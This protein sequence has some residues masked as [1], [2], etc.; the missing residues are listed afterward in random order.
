M[1]LYKWGSLFLD[2]SIGLL[3]LSAIVRTV[4]AVRYARLNGSG[5]PNEEQK[6]SL[7]KMTLPIAVAGLVFGIASLVLLL[8][9]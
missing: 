1:E 4:L 2:I 7:R 9:C 3:L 6:K 5:S 8:V